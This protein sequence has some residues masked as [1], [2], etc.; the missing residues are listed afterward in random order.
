MSI[1]VH[2][3]FTC[4]VF[5]LIRSI[6]T[7][8]VSSVGCSILYRTNEGIFFR[9]DNSIYLDQLAGASFSTMFEY[10]FRVPNNKIQIQHFI[11]AL[12]PLLFTYRR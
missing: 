3:Q 1:P 9:Y 10:N 4:K 5:T 6:Y 2:I 12:F 7:L 11:R 8:T